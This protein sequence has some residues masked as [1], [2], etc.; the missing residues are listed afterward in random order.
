MTRRLTVLSRLGHGANDMYWFILPAVIPLILREYGFSYTAAG[1]FITAF[2]CAM[3]VM[4]FFM[5]RLADS[6]SRRVLISGGFFMASGSLAVAGIMPTFPLFMVFVLLT[7]VGASTYHPVIYAAID[8]AGV[9]RRGRM[10]ARFEMFGALGVVTL[11]VANGLLIDQIGWQAMVFI[12]C[13]P[14][15]I[16]GGLFAVSRRVVD[17]GVPED[18]DEAQAT[19]GVHGA[20]VTAA[21][22]ADA[23]GS[24]GE[25]TDAVR[26]SLLT[27]FFVSIILRTLTA[28]S[29][30]NFMPTYLSEAVG[31][32]ARLAAFAAGLLFVG[33]VGANVLVGPAA[34]RFGAVRVLLAG[35][36]VAGTFLILSTYT[37]A[38]WMLPVSLLILGGSISAAIPAQNLILSSLSRCG[39]KGTAFGALMGIMTIANSLGPLALGAIADRIGLSHT[40]RLAAVPVLVSCVLVVFL[41]RDSVFRV[42]QTRRNDAQTAGAS[43]GTG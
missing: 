29:I 7:A 26:R 11:F 16:V 23:D 39:R 27:A 30:M 21:G 9:V 25:P 32:D 6:A 15:V 38:A 34:D 13:V 1:A 18:R 12:V 19:S 41:S 17:H 40:F 3:A 33:A 35:S 31:L 4:S 42:L 5:G 20:D 10:F 2:L 8:E 37:V 36:L 14:G 22:V 43:S 28:T 24:S